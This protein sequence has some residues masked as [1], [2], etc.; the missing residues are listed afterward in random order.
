MAVSEPIRRLIADFDARRPAALARAVSIVENHRVGFDLLL[1][2][3]HG[4][5]GHARRI[6]VTGPPG[7]GTSTLTT[8][9][10][11]FYREQGL[12]V[13]SLAVKEDE[14]VCAVCD[15]PLPARWNF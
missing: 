13:G 4:R 11:R 2:A 10:A 14:F 6:G 1:A 3:L 7:A 9:L 12:T 15:A 8:Q 5:L